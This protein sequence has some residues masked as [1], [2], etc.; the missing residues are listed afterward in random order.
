MNLH[1]HRTARIT[2]VEVKRVND[3][4][5]LSFDV[6][7]DN[8]TDNFTLYFNSEEEMREQLKGMALAILEAV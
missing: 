5:W 1:I 4:R 8:A 3:S 7:A 6:V 2:D